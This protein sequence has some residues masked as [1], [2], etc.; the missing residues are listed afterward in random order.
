VID[1]LLGCRHAGAFTRE[2]S[3]QVG[4]W[5]VRLVV[6]IGLASVLIVEGGSI[7]LA[8]IAASE[9]ASGSA[10]EAAFAVRA[11]GLQGSPDTQARALVKE[12]GCELLA[13]SFNH[14]EQKVSTT[15]RCRAKTYLVRRIKPLEK[16]TVVTASHI[17]SFATR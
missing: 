15:V 2:D 14:S 12:K 3:G 9:A 6:F 11:Q 10:S 17:S 8:R 13:I 7:V 16:Y 1:D 5:L 4:N